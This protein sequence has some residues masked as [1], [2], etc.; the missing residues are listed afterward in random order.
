M[1]AEDGAVAGEAPVVGNA[2]LVVMK[3][4]ESDESKAAAAISIPVGFRRSRAG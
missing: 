3:A 4:T 1:A 2:V